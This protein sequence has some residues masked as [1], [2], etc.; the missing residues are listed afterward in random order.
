MR[1]TGVA[2]DRPA[3]SS[4]LVDGAVLGGRARGSGRR[5][6]SCVTGCQGG[7]DLVPR[8]RCEPPHSNTAKN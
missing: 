4:P 2:L 7:Q 1:N 6:T 8:Q 5:R 3:V